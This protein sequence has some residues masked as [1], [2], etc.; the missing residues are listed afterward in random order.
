MQE[1]IAYTMEPMLEI[2][3]KIYRKVVE[4]TKDFNKLSGH[5]ENIQKAVVFLQISSNGF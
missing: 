2:L 1:W 3:S 4:L 5:Q